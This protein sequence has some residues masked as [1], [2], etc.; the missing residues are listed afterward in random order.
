MS[1]DRLLDPDFVRFVRERL[2]D[3]VPFTGAGVSADAGVPVADKLAL[4]IADGTNDRGAT[5][6]RVEDFAAVC[7][8]VTNALGVD[9][10]KDVVAEV[11]RGLEI[12]PTPLLRSI[13]RT[14]SKI[15]LTSNYDDGLEQAAREVGLT[16]RTF[17]PRMAPA[18]GQPAAGEV[19]IVHIHGVATDPASI[20][21]PGE[22]LEELPRD[23]PFLVGL[24]ALFAPYTLVYLGYRFQRTHISAPNSPGS[25]QTSATRANTHCS[26]RR[27]STRHA[28]PS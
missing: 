6:D 23:E 9:Q 28:P 14:P 10:L 11:I 20:I 12:R 5:V 25:R 7:G 18:F 22:P 15:V 3:V 26:F 4:L 13:V 27:T 24:R 21:V 8:A 1:Q 17:E 16:P 19:F 2:P